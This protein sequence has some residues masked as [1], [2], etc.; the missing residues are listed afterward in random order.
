MDDGLAMKEVPRP[1]IAA[2]IEIYPSEYAWPK[3][4]LVLRV[5]PVSVTEN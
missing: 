4:Y 3:I 1:R 5:A 2:C